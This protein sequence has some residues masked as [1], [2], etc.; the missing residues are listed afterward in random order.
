[1]E[2]EALSFLE[3]GLQDAPRDWRFLLFLVS[4]LFEDVI[5]EGICG[6][7]GRIGV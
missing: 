3:I 7:F 2:E 4:V 5:D 6:R 1:M